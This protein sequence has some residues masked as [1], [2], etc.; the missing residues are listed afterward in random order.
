LKLAEIDLIKEKTRD[1]P[2]LILDDVLSELDDFRKNHLLNYISNK[3]Q[4]FVT[5][6]SIDGLSHD[7]IENADKFLVEDGIVISNNGVRV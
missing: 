7:I 3:V 4:T 5:T 6:T 2:I 1:Y